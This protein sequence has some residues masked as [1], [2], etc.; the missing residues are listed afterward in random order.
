VL[1]DTAGASSSRIC[2]STSRTR[3]PTWA[4]SASTSSGSAAS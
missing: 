1:D 2:R 3:I 4:A